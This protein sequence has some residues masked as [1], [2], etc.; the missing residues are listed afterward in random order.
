MTRHEP[1]RNLR[2]H[3]HYGFAIRTTDL[4][5]PLNATFAAENTGQSQGVQ[6]TSGR[7]FRKTPEPLQFD[8]LAR[9]GAIVGKFLADPISD[10][11]TSAAAASQAA[12]DLKKT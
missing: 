5:L 2:I 10:P 8:D 3:R 7:Y 4:S 11:S 12:S 6:L 1:F 9:D